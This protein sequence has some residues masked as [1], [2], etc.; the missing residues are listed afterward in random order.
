[1][2]NR[3]L[4][5]F[6]ND[7]TKRKRNEQ[8]KN[9]VPCYILRFLAAVSNC[10]IPVHVP[11]QASAEARRALPDICSPAPSSASCDSPPIGILAHSSSSVR[12]IDQPWRCP[13]LYLLLLIDTWKTI[14]IVALADT[15]PLLILKKTFNKKVF[16][17]SFNYVPVNI[18]FFVTIFEFV[19]FGL[20]STPDKEMS[21][22]RS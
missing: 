20:K 1:M 14:S 9:Q 4:S 12:H 6:H 19:H 7:I 3:Y 16:Q 11:V 5:Y 13:K 8:S 22:L 10:P 15:L 17:S 2:K 21:K 18:Y